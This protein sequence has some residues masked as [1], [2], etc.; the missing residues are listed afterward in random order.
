MFCSKTSNNI[1]NKLH[2]RSI[3]TILNDY[4]SDFNILLE[5]KNGIRNHLGNIQALLIEAFKMKNGLVC[6]GKKKNRLVWS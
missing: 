4:I 6:D 2:E 5:N 3:R 1:I